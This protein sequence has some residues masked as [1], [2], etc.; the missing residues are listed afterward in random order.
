M[1]TR[2][3]LTVWQAIHPLKIWPIEGDGIRCFQKDNTPEA[4]IRLQS[5]MRRI[6]SVF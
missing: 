6:S 5:Y 1:T 3:H 4:R 2:T